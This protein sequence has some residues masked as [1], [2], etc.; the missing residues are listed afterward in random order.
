[1]ITDHQNDLFFSS[2]SLINDIHNVKEGSYFEVT[3]SSNFSSLVI[4]EFYQFNI[5]RK[6]KYSRKGNLVWVMHSNMGKMKNYIKVIFDYS[7]S[8]KKMKEKRFYNPT[9]HY[10]KKEAYDKKGHLKAITYYRKGIPYCVERFKTPGV[11]L[12]SVYFHENGLQVK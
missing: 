8:K 9:F 11:L 3:Y 10:L 7:F 5:V 1:M 4:S 6:Y 12:E 2:T